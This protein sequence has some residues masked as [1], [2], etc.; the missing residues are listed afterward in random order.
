MKTEKNDFTF[1]YKGRGHY[2][3][4]YTS[5]TTRMSWAVV[6]DNM[7]LIDAT[8]NQESPKLK[9]LSALK[10]LCKRGNVKFRNA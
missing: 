3:V 8:K 1:E 4:V 2:R 7:P 9:D 5:P 10:A 6:T